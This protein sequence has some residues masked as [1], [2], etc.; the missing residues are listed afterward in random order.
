MAMLLLQEAALNSANASNAAYRQVTTR[1]IAKLRRDN[2]QNST[3]NYIQ[4]ALMFRSIM[5]SPPPTS[6][7]F[8]SVVS[9]ETDQWAEPFYDG[10]LRK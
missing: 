4:H 3:S 6:S 7:L 5:A 9:R 1:V 10:L 8:S 2:W